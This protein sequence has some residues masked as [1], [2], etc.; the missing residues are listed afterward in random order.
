MKNFLTACLVTSEV[1]SFQIPVFSVGN[2]VSNFNR[3]AQVVCNIPDDDD[4]ASHIPAELNKWKKSLFSNTFSLDTRL[5]SYPS[6]YKLKDSKICNAM[7]LIERIRNV[8]N[9]DSKQVL[10]QELVALNMLLNKTEVR[11]YVARETIEK[12]M[13]YEVIRT[14]LFMGV[15]CSDINLGV[16]PS[17]KLCKAIRITDHQ[18]DEERKWLIEGLSQITVHWPFKKDE[19][20]YKI[21][22]LIDLLNQVG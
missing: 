8:D 11:Q 6:I 20:K 16:E 18:G 2:Q 9:Y 5:R 22:K 15:L 13:S 12:P 3:M 1:L 17:L 21:D 7:G 14:L 10:T 19:D 4:Q